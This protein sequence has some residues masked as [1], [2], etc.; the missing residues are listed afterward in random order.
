VLPQFKTD[1]SLTTK[2]KHDRSCAYG[3]M[4]HVK[5]SA[6][7][8]WM[9]IALS[10]NRSLAAISEWGVGNS[11]WRGVY[12]C[13][14]EFLG[15]P[16]EN[17]ISS[18]QLKRRVFMVRKVR[19]GLQITRRKWRCALSVLSCWS[20]VRRTAGNTHHFHCYAWRKT[21]LQSHCCQQTEVR[22]TGEWQF[23]CRLQDWVACRA[24][25]LFRRNIDM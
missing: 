5:G 22:L 17:V 9:W 19:A 13:D 14:V 15:I 21:S 10:S 2:S 6:L 24:Y 4:C 18:T 23:V 11:L 25:F 12:Q 7:L 8:Q 20:V 16:F 1:V 3:D